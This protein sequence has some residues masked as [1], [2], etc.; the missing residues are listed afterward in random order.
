[1]SAVKR[2][3]REWRLMYSSVPSCGYGHIMAFAIKNQGNMTVLIVEI[4]QMTGFLK[5][6]GDGN[7]LFG[8]DIL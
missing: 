2:N 4:S 6:Y 5:Q 1:M 8:L 7:W 3:A